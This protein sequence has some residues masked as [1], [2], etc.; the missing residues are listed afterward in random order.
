MTLKSLST[1]L[2]YTLLFCVFPSHAELSSHEGADLEEALVIGYE[3]DSPPYVFTNKQGEE[4]GFS[5]ALTKIIANN[6]GLHVHFKEAAWHE[7]RKALETGVIDGVT[8]MGY[9]DQR[10]QSVEFSV[11][12]LKDELALFQDKYTAAISSIRD[13]EGKKVVSL[14]GGLSHDYL[15]KN[16][17]GAEL[18]TVDRWPDVLSHLAEGKADFAMITKLAGLY[19]I[20][21]QQHNNL[22][23]VNLEDTNLTMHYS[24]AVKKGDKELLEQINEGIKLAQ[25][26]GQFDDLYLH[27]FG[28]L[29]PKTLEES[30][31][32]TGIAVVTGIFAVIFTFILTWSLLLKRQAKLRTLF[33]QAEIKGRQQA[34]DALKK[35]DASFRALFMNAGIGMST[36]DKSGHFTSVNPA[37]CKMLGYREE[38]LK[39]LSIQNVSHSDDIQQVKADLELLFN[40]KDNRHHAE[41]RYLKKGGGVFWGSATGTVLND[42][43][44][45]KPFCVYMIEDTSAQRAALVSAEQMQ[46]YF[47]DLFQLAPDAILMVDDQGIIRM[48]NRKAVELFGWTHDELYGQKIEALVPSNRRK[49]HVGLRED[50]SKK[51]EPRV[52]ASNITN[53]RAVRKNGT[54]FPVEISLGHIETK[55][56]PMIATTVRNISNRL[57]QEDDRRALLVAERANAAKSTFLATMS[58]EIRTPMNGVVGCVDLLA[59]SS[60]DSEQAEL[61]ET[62]SDSSQALLTVINDILDFSKIEAGEMELEHEP[63][64]LEKKFDSVCAAMEP[65]VQRKHLTMH[66]F[67]DPRLPEVILSDSVR[68]RQILSNLISN[69]IKFTA[70]NGKIIVRAD[71]LGESQLRISVADNGIGM[72]PEV[73][74]ALFNPFMQAETSTTR[75]Y[76]GTGLGLSICKRLA[77]M[78]GGSIEVSS[79]L[80]CGSTFSVTLPLEPSPDTSYP[81]S[82]EL[83][84]LH[85]LVVT[86]D[87]QKAKDWCAYLDNAGASSEPIVDPAVAQL[88][89]TQSPPET[90]FVVMEETVD[91]TRQWFDAQA[92]DP[93]PSLVL[94]GKDYRHSPTLIEPSVVAL[95]SIGMSRHRF[96]EAV[97]ISTGQIQAETTEDLLLHQGV[98]L[99]PPSRDQ[100]IE[101][102]RLIL[103]AEDNDIN[104]KIITRQLNLLGYAVDV[105]ENGCIAL[106]AWQKGCY[107]LLLTDLHMPKMDGYELTQTIRKQESSTDARIPIVALTANALKGE[108][109]RCL[110]V[111]MDQYLTKPIVLDELKASLERWLSAHNEDS[112]PVDFE[113]ATTTPVT[114]ASENAILDTSVLAELIGDDPAIIEEFLLDY[115]QSAEQSSVEMRTALSRQN[116]EEVR[117]LAHRLK[118]S[119]RAVGALPLGECCEQIELSLAEGDDSLHKEFELALEDVLAV[120]DKKVSVL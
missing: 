80:G 115:R 89:M 112:R 38:E 77:D 76:G 91:L 13:L 7:S 51:Y 12:Y 2:F 73:Q 27:W 69:A 33:L 71:Q 94:L 3:S 100:A 41:T 42:T 61:V 93:K 60:L 85:C 11:P 105:T 10:A 37:L 34:E 101:Q 114:D 83:S 84:G 36:I 6:Q 74:E 53:L 111:G 30:T 29:E 92:S 9:S 68:L 108:S 20:K 15:E 118:S 87:L 72:K 54:E 59:R 28:G 48:L 58:H 70:E 110:V 65:L 96:L 106:D 46:H 104:Q 82:A 98:M 32:L 66:V 26:S 95:S 63:L 102:G 88:R 50:H 57:Q 39:A 35:S 56:G 17:T 21:E 43:E 75:Q 47:Q 18:I 45:G 97:N 81:V 103:V 86:Q 99:T 44:N 22:V 4:D 24:F 31:V 49:H 113:L 78:L 23:Y 14:S 117:S 107:G 116:W 64:S 67:T 109:D 120:I 25:V 16:A 79:E 8:T 1:L 5:V 40:T 90:T 119:S 52:M 55:N 19:F 62:M